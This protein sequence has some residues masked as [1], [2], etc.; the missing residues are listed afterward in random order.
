MRGAILSLLIVASVADAAGGAEPVTL[1]VGA[2]R[3]VDG[4]RDAA[5]RNRNSPREA[6][7]SGDALTAFYVREAVQAAMTLPDDVVA[8]ALLVGLA[9]G[10]DR[11]PTL[12]S[13]P[14][15]SRRLAGVESAHDRQ[16]RA[17]VL[18]RPT[19]GGRGDLAL[20]VAVSMGLTVLAGP[21]MAEALGLAKEM[22]DARAGSGFSFAD[23]AANLIGIELARRLLDGSLT[24]L[25]LAAEFETLDVGPILED[26][27]EG[28]PLDQFRD[29]YGSTVDPRFRQMR[30]LIEARIQ[31]LPLVP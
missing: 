8:P 25:Q 12:V 5:V 19:L 3:V 23:Y 14:L 21:Q 4:I 27:P 29:A 20:H 15:F 17:A 16:Q 11:R 28:L 13:N 10:L 24:P 7:V 26:L 18:G 31:A 1:V 2:R 22:D 30:T 6:R 9:V